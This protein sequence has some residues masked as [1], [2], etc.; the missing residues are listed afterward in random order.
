MENKTKNRVTQETS[1]LKPE[2]LAK[3]NEIAQP[4]KKEKKGLF[5]FLKKKNKNK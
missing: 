5:G 4:A 1:I 2:D 3:I